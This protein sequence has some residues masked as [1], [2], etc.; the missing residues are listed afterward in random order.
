[1]DQQGVSK[2]S[3]DARDRGYIMLEG[4]RIDGGKNNRNIQEFYNVEMCI[5]DRAISD[6]SNPIA[7]EVKVGIS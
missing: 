2:I 5:R 4:T 6:L 1:M 7:S 3:G